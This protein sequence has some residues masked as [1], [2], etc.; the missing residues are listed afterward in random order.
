MVVN[1]KCII[2]STNDKGPQP[3]SFDLSE[4]KETVLIKALRTKIQNKY[5][6]EG[7]VS[8]HRSHKDAKTGKLVPD[9][10][11]KG[12]DMTLKE[13]E[14]IFVLYNEKINVA[15]GGYG[16]GAQIRSGIGFAEGGH[17]V[18]GSRDEKGN[19]VGGDGAGGDAYGKDITGAGGEGF[20][21]TAVPTAPDKTGEAGDG[22]GGRLAQTLHSGRDH[23][24]RG[25][26]AAPKA[27][28]STHGHRGKSA[29]A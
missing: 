27:G 22:I 5:N 24:T 23:T 3:K 25:D 21:G 14:T 8:I 20:G 29:K 26:Q 16:E 11:L 2:Q 10:E 19:T 12:V 7:L 18:G 6:I 4:K 28:S 17:G 1:F 9:P 13:D 15:S